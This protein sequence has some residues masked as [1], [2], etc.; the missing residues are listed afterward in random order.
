M[1]SFNTSNKNTTAQINIQ[2]IPIILAKRGIFFL[3]VALV[4]FLGFIFDG[5]SFRVVFFSEVFFFRLI[6]GGITFLGFFLD[7]LFFLGFNFSRSSVTVLLSVGCT[8]VGLVVAGSW[9]VVII[10]DVVGLFVVLGD[11]RSV[12]SPTSGAGRGRG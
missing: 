3:G 2:V 1:K 8:S 6:F 4:F 7:G 11:C 10:P 12:L 5:T 9:A